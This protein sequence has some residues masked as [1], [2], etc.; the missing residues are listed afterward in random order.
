MFIAENDN[1]REI[2]NQMNGY[3][4]DHEGYLT[5]LE[6]L[7]VFKAESKLSRTISSSAIQ[8][9]IYPFQCSQSY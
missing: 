8:E 2:M 4:N 1:A 3:N 7:F 6:N 5:T 9:K